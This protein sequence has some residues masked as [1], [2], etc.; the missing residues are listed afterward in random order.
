MS[1]STR[2]AS[3]EWAFGTVLQK[4]SNW[5]EAEPGASGSP[6]DKFHSLQLL[7][8]GDFQCLIAHVHAHHVDS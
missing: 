6:H 1:L 4:N 7:F 2:P 3:F 8:Q 5:A